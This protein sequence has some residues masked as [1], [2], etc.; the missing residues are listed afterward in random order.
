MASTN[1]HCT[2]RNLISKQFPSISF[3]HVTAETGI[4]N[5]LWFCQDLRLLKK[6]AEEKKSEV[7]IFKKLLY[8]AY[9]TAVH[10]SRI[11]GTYFSHSRKVA[12]KESKVYNEAHQKPNKKDRIPSKATLFV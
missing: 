5:T 4:C 10:Y 6:F 8:N 9:R 12:F 1:C 3:Q 7:Q 11:R 2:I